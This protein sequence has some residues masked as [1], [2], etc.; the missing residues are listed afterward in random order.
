QPGCARTPNRTA[1]I[2]SSE[3][4]TEFNRHGRPKGRSLCIAG[5]GAAQIA[6]PSLRHSLVRIHPD[7]ARWGHGHVTLA[8]AR[9]AHTVAGTV[10]VFTLCIMRGRAGVVV[11]TEKGAE[12]RDRQKA[13]WWAHKC[14]L[15]Q[16]P[17]FVVD[18]AA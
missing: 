8:F 17:D 16:N 11:A 9:L 1:A 6:G 4:P 12:G 14:T 7:R 3:Q 5:M 2:G 13:F 10:A 15:A 18:V